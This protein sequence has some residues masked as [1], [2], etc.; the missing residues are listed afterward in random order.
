MEFLNYFFNME[1]NRFKSAHIKNGNII[2]FIVKSLM[3]I[4]KY[5]FN[6]S[7][8]YLITRSQILYTRNC[9]KYN[10]NIPF[11]TNTSKSISIWWKNLICPVRTPIK[12]IKIAE[13]YRTNKLVLSYIKIEI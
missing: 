13:Q 4:T 7:S 8:G 10:S 3:S 9:Q 6:W 5:I 12:Y 2:S 1:W 11:Q